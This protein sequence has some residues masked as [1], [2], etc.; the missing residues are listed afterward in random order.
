MFDWLRDY[1]SDYVLNT[2]NSLFDRI[3]SL[4][5]V[6]FLIPA[7]PF[8]TQ[9]ENQFGPYYKASKTLVLAYTLIL[10]LLILW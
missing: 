4:I 3:W 10:W 9:D 6:L 2:D 1:F 7:W 5:L 8:I